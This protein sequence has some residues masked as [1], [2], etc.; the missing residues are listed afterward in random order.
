M[1]ASW[2]MV[3]AQGLR[4]MTSGYKTGYKFN[5]LIATASQKT[6]DFKGK[7]DVLKF[8]VND[9]ANRWF[10]PLTHVSEAAIP[11]VTGFSCQRRKRE[12]RGEQRYGWLQRWLQFVCRLFAAPSGAE[13]RAIL[14]QWIHER[15]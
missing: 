10:Q 12:T 13:R 4:I 5:G 8:K 1:V 7:C 14:P 3:R 9:L 15:F 2:R 11:R 6:A